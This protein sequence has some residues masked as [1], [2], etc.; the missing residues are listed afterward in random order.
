MHVCTVLKTIIFKRFN[1]YLKRMGGAYAYLFA[2][3]IHCC[4]FDISTSRRH[5]NKTD[6]AFRFL[7]HDILIDK[8][9]TCAFECVDFDDTYYL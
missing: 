7:P 8:Q 4:Q 1:I 3:T 6:F 9:Y 2:H 5:D